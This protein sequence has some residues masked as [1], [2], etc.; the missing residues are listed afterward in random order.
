MT[1]QIQAVT[2]YGKQPGQMRTVPFRTGSLNI[3]TGDSRRGKSALLTI[4]DYCLASTDYPVK[5][6]KVRDYVSAY[7]VTL[8]R[9]RQQL[10]VARRAPEG[11]AAVS[12]VLCVLT[13]ATGT[14]APRLEDLHFSTPQDTAKDILSNF[15][16]IDSTVRVPAVGKNTLIAPSVRHALFFCFQA[17]NEVA[18]PDVLFHS[19]GEDWKPNTIRGVIPYFLGAVDREQALLQNRLRNLR[20]DLADNEA[21]LATSTDVAPA[22]GQAQALLVEAIEV[23]LVPPQA[24]PH[25]ADELLR[26]LRNAMIH[27]A[28]GDSLADEDPLSALHTRRTELRRLFSQTRARIADLKTDLAENSDFN[29]QAIEQRARLASLGLLN[30][31][32]NAAADQA[33]CPVCDGHVPSANETVAGLM[34]D[35]SHLD[36]D[37]Q[38]IG[39]DTP[40]IRRLIVD[41]EGRLQALRSELARNQEEINELTTALRTIHRE[42]DDLRRAAIVQGR[43]SLF[44]DTAAQHAAAPRVQDRREALREQIAEL[45]DQLSGSTQEERLTSFLSLINQEIKKKAKALDLDFSGSPIRLDTSRLTVVADTIDGPVQ[46]KSMGSAE[47][48]LGYHISTLLSLHEWFAKHQGPVPRVLIL[49]QP[50]QVYFPAEATGDEELQTNDRLHLLNV[51]EVLHHTLQQLDGEL[52]IIV[53]EHA[54]LADPMFSQHVVER[55]RYG[56]DTALVPSSW[57]EP[58]ES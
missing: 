53:M 3:V 6:G 13:Q 57:M 30:R 19:Q 49:D 25:T 5:A 17:Q 37:L 12:T 31:D 26:H 4:I 20:R 58:E 16:G 10:F 50:S 11:K 1:F 54:D 15:C 29:D 32:A 56:N 48:H 35:L 7:A 42:P 52:Q 22:S 55:W 41:G 34:R 43:I 2:I 33:R 38:V 51:F 8:I 44:L 40:A 36:G 46:L 14:P 24:G 28:P 23:G 39:S 9:G 45:E 47:N 18:N 27:N 21:M